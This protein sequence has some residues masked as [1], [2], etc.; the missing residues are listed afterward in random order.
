M[1]LKIEGESVGKREIKNPEK[2]E[3][4]EVVLGGDDHSKTDPK[5][6]S[7]YFRIRCEIFGGKFSIFYCRNFITVNG[8]DHDDSA[9]KITKQ[10]IPG[11]K[12]K[13][14]LQN[15]ISCSS[16]EIVGE[17]PYIFNVKKEPQVMETLEKFGPE[18]EIYFDLKVDDDLNDLREFI[19]F[20]SIDKD[21]KCAKVK[22]QNDCVDGMRIPE[23]LLDRD[24]GAGSKL[25]FAA[26]IN[27][28]TGFMKDVRGFFCTF[29]ASWYHVVLTQKKEKVQAR[30]KLI[31]Q[32]LYYCD[33]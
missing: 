15:K 3:N 30:P 33:H 19:R 17:D 18:Y 29:T 9:F 12:G 21:E 27:R 7:K 10:T 5:A 6:E 4:V 14:Y 31:G 26:Y 20:S 25:Y 24:S 28:A 32:I 11:A 13:K 8:Q 2:M 1:E 16:I 22:G 23:L